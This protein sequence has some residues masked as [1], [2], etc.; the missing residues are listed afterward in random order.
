MNLGGEEG[1]GAQWFRRGRGR[2]TTAKLLGGGKVGKDSIT[3]TAE[4]GD[5]STRMVYDGH[6]SLC[7]EDGCP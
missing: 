1:H 6:R 3:R 5:C 2:E 7:D 4:T